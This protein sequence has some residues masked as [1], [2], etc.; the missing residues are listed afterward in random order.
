MW[1]GS[2]C[3][4]RPTPGRRSF[5]RLRRSG[6]LALCPCEGGREALS[7]VLGGSFNFTCN[8]ATRAVK[9]LHLRHQ[10]RV[11]RQCRVQ[12]RPERH[13]QRVLCRVGK[14]AEVGE[15]WSLSHLYL[16]S[17]SRS[18]IK[19][20]QYLGIKLAKDTV[21]GADRWTPG[22]QLPENYRERH[23]TEITDAGWGPGAILLCAG[24]SSGPIRERL[25]EACLGADHDP[26][27]W[28]EA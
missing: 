10:F 1:S 15:R 27:P 16:D 20:N 4:S 14:L 6:L 21:R 25:R 19:E 12:L 13:D 22:E 18:P 9:G 7:G 11:E 2:G 23:W 24:L 3:S 26:S 28:N 5:R 8:S 17:R